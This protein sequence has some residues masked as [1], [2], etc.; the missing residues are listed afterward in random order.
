MPILERL[1]YGFLRYFW[2][3]VCVLI[4]AWPVGHPAD[5]GDALCGLVL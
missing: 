4:V 1:V 2:L 5:E 3:T